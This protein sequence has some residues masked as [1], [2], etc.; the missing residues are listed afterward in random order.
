MTLSD[1]D[2]NTFTEF[3]TE[4]EPVRISTASFEAGKEYRLTEIEA[5]EGFTVP[6]E[7]ADGVVFRVN[8]YGDVILSLDY[9]QAK[10]EDGTFTVYD[11]KIYSVSIT[12]T[13]ITTGAELEGAELQLLNGDGEIID[14]WKSSLETHVIE[15]LVP[16]TEYT[17]REVTAPL[18]YTVTADTVFTISIDGTVTANGTEVPDGIILIEDDP[19]RVSV[20]KVDIADGREIE[21][22]H[23]RLM[24]GDAVIEEWDSTTAPHTINSILRPGAV[25]VLRETAAPD[26]YTIASD[27]EFTVD[28]TGRV[29]TSSTVTEDGIILIEDAPIRVSVSKVD[30]ADGREIEGAHIQ[31]IDGEDVI[32]EWDS[33]TVPHVITALLKPDHEYI[34]RETVA[35]DGY[36]IASDTTFT[37]DSTGRVI[38]SS[39]VTED[40]VILIEDTA[41]KVSVS[42]VDIADGREIEGAHIQLIDGDTVIEEWDST[43]VSHVITTLL[44][45]DHEYILRET[46]APDGYTVA[47]DT[48]FTVDS[49][50]RVITSSTV[51]EDGIILIEDEMIAENNDTELDS[52]SNTQSTDGNTDTVKINGQDST[53]NYPSYTPVTYEDVKAPSLVSPVGGKNDTR[54]STENGP[55][56]DVAAGAGM[57]AVPDTARHSSAAVIMAAAG[58]IALMTRKKK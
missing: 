33:T 48:T 13:D 19:I 45:P 34:L 29:T 36:T 9:E 28:S 5:P 57:M 4:E 17:L 44:K 14:E 11:D 47:S 8:E 21:G 42:K 40:G 22:A 15:G 56:E 51:T 2:G 1:A 6:A 50:G 38:T 18:G 58:A 32:E 16:D 27:T 41:V 20:S 46:V 30:I 12:K 35:P 37:V 54:T 26:G 25:Y 3:E 49:T 53:V 55:V 43:T 39:T 52:D 10:S 31:L 23:I 7:L 24:E